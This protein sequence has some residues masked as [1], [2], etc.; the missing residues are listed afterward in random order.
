MKPW[1]RW[2][3]IVVC[4]VLFTTIIAVLFAIAYVDH[5][6]RSLHIEFQ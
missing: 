2:T 4:T 5:Y 1:L 3:L 6:V